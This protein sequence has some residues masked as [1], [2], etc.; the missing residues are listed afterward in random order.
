MRKRFMLS[1]AFLLLTGACYAQ[2]TAKDSLRLN[3]LLKSSE[4]LKLNEE[5]VKR[6][7]P[8]CPYGR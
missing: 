4:E 8:G 7:P 1:A 6:I 2:W 3:E 5:A